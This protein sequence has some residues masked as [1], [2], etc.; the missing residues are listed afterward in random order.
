M[1]AMISFLP[2][3][4]YSPSSFFWIPQSVYLIFLQF[5][6]VCGTCVKGIILE[7]SFLDVVEEDGALE[8]HTL[9]KPKRCL[10]SWRIEKSRRRRLN[11]RKREEG[12]IRRKR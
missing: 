7:I 1:G 2:G 10:K 3:K 12:L 5:L 11:R 4:S 6:I 9:L 8:N